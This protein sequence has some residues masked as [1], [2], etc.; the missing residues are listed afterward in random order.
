M[1]VRVEAPH[2]CAGL[3]VR[4]GVC[5]WTAPIL[6]WAKGLPED[7]LRNRFRSHGWKA[8]IV[9]KTTIPDEYAS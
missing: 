2:F 6:R 5:V 1:L 3:L 7:E 4:G 9:R 8:T